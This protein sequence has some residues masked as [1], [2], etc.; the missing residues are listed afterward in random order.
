MKIV[1]CAFVKWLTDV[2]FVSSFV[3]VIAKKSNLPPL[4]QIG[5]INIAKWHKQEQA[6]AMTG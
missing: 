2:L 4:N 6:K 3:F 1:Q 5:D